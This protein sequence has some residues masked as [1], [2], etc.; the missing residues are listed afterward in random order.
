MSLMMSLLPTSGEFVSEFPSPRVNL[1]SSLLL[2]LTGLGG[3]ARS[4]SSRRHLSRDHGE[5]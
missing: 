3:P 2:D 5:Y 4:L 1:T